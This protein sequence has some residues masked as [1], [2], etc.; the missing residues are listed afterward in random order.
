MPTAS[1]SNAAK[2]IGKLLEMMDKEQ[3]VLP[4]IQRDFVWT[5]KSIKLLIDSLYRGLPIGHMLVW[6]AQTTVDAKTF[7]KRKMKRGIR[8]DGFYGYLLDGQQRLTA[9]AHLRDGDEEYPLMFYVWPEREADEE[10]T[11]YWRGKNEP[12]DPWCIPVGEVLSDD[13]SV[14]DRLNTIKA[15]EWFKPGHEEIIRRD[16]SAMQAIRDYD[17]GVTEF[18]TDD[19]KLATELFVRFNSTGS[20]LRRSDLS[21]AELAIHVPGLVSKDIRQAQNRWRDFRF[22]MPFLV[23]C[24]LAVHTGRFRL[25]ETEQAWSDA[26]PSEVKDAWRKTERAI[27]KMIEFLTGTVRWTSASLI[28]SFNALIPLVVVLANGNIWSLQEKRLARRWLLLASVHGYFSGSVQ[29]QLDKVLRGMQPD[30]SMTMLWNSTKRSLRRLRADDF[31][32]GRLSGPVM[33]LF[34][35][36]I[37]DR[38]A[39][40]WQNTDSPLDG[41]VVGHGAALHVHHFFPRALLNKRKEL[42]RAEINTFANYSVIS[43]STNLD[44][45]SE[46]PATYLDRIPVP[47]DELSK[48]CIPLNRDLWHVGRYNEFLAQRRKLLA[49]EANK[50]LGV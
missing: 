44:V 43:A 24:L 10:E 1:A 26:K 12:D 34:L 31:Q 36:M 28:P 23:Q 37:R 39:K 38:G 20:K 29:T 9:L 32:T 22:T 48:Q 40:D 14:T 19:Y 30:P 8:L 50:F 42:K 11:L 47:E 17:V 27:G 21:I 41:T 18:E 4:E 16:L 2:K 49:E 25:K 5:K 3:L 6:K 45:L 13:F 15:S 46:E 7:D 35:S 33:S